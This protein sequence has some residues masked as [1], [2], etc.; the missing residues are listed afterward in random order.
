M[1]YSNGLVNINGNTPPP[2]ESKKKEIQP[3]VIGNDDDDSSSDEEITIEYI[4]DNK[5]KV[6]IVREF[7]KVNLENTDIPDWLS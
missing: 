6:K 5:P 7:M 2:R 3:M 1:D 4:I